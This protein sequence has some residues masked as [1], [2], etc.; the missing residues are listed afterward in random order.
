[1]W[2]SLHSISF[3]YPAEPT[4]TERRVYRD[5]FHLLEHVIPCEA[6]RKHYAE[7]LREDPIDPA[8]E[9]RETL[10]RWVIQIHNRINVRLGKKVLPEDE[11]Y[12]RYL[13]AYAGDQVAQRSLQTAAVAGATGPPTSMEGASGPGLSGDPSG[14]GTRRSPRSSVRTAVLG[15]LLLLCVLCM[16][17]GAWWWWR[18]H[19]GSLSWVVPTSPAVTATK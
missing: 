9:S 1:M 10:A 15:V 3:S 8:L 16:G 19:P 6:C 4:L 13:A 2:F 17:G 11:V 14:G 5:F 12:S 7:T 18:R